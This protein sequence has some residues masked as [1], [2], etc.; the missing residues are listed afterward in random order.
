MFDD[1]I[2]QHFTKIVCPLT[3]YVDIGHT[4]PPLEVGVSADDGP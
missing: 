3:G 4:T 2:L 1:Y